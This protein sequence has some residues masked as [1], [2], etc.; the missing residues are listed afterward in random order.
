M[1]RQQTRQGVRDLGVR[2]PVKLPVERRD[3][4]R[5]LVGISC[6]HPRM[7]DC[8]VFEGRNVCGHIA[9]PDCGLTCDLHSG[10]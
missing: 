10:Y 9:C 2:F 8:C 1:G 7:R 6:V 3:V 5:I 4:R